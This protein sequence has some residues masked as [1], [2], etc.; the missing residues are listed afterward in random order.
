[1]QRRK[2]ATFSFSEGGKEEIFRNIFNVD[3]SKDTNIPSKI[4]E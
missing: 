2:H 4:F 1:M 3:V